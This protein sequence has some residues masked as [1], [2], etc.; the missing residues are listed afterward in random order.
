MKGPAAPSTCTIDSLV[1]PKFAIH[2]RFHF[3]FIEVRDDDDNNNNEQT[4]PISCEYQGRIRIEVRRV[5]IEASRNTTTPDFGEPK[6][7]K[8]APKALL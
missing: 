8:R 7:A 3:R 6:K 2:E 5:K 1:L 4:W